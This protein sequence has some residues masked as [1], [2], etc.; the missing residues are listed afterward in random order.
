MKPKWHWTN[1]K[2]AQE[3]IARISE[4][5]RGIPNPHKG[6]PNPFKGKKLPWIGH[7][8][9]HSEES[10]I[11]MSKNVVT[12]IGK[13]HH[14]WKGNGVG[15]IALHSWVK[16]KLGCPPKCEKCGFESK[17]NHKIHWANKSHK[18]KRDLNDWI[19]LCVPCHKRFDIDYKNCII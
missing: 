11:L 18:Y 13:K 16:R 9:P 19:R 4:K 1:Q 12:R 15:M 7:N 8:K 10:K 6:N 5:K 14:F 3:I 17:S 2:N